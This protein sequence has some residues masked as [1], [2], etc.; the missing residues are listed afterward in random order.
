MDHP[1][2]K[3]PRA[4]KPEESESEEITG[5]VSFGVANLRREPTSLPYV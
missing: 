2:E 3:S 4:V 1:K 5:H